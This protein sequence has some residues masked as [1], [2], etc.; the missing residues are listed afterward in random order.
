MFGQ[1][2]GV[3]APSDSIPDFLMFDATAHAVPVK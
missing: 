2:G 1:V 3:W